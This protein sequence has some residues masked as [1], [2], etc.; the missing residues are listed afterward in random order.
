MPPRLRAVSPSERITLVGST[1]LLTGATGGIGQAIAHNLAARGVRLIL[2]GR[3]RAELERLGDDLGVE[4]IVCDLSV[5]ADVDRLAGEAVAAGV[6]ILIA[7]AAVP[8]T[9]WLVDLPPEQIDGMLD[10]NLRAPIV[11]ARALAPVM[12]ARGRGHMV[13]ISSLSGKFAGPASS[14]YSATKFGLRGFALGLREDLRPRGVGVS[15]LAPGFIRDAG[16]YVKSGVKLPPG[17]G[18]KSPQEVADAVIRAIEHNQAELD[19]A[20]VSLRLGTAIG[21]V[22]PALAA[23]GSRMMGSERVGSDY[24]ESQ[25]DQR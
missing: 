24:A 6:E 1:A 16:M 11:L 21:S 2:T 12:A 23:W 7:N 25:R 3:R 14:I 9:G 13:F 19:V 20:P 8:A 18:T 4:T 22:A 17:V 15:V 10:V 5:R